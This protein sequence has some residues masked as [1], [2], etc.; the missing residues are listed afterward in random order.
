MEAFFEQIYSILTVPPGSLAYHLV[1]AFSIA[2]AL[3]IAVSAW[4]KSEGAH[5]RRWMLGL[6]LLLFLQVVQFGMAALGWQ[7]IIPTLTVLP[8][9][10]RGVSLLS[11]L[12][13]AWVWSFPRSSRLGDTAAVLLGL[14]IAAFMV[15]SISW[16]GQQVPGLTFNQTWL[17][18]GVQLFGILLAGLAGAGLL[19]RR[20]V[21]WGYGFGMLGLLM[22]GH[23]LQAWLLPEG[24]FAGIHRIFQMAAYPLLLLL[25]RPP[26]SVHNESEFIKLESQTLNRNQTLELALIRDYTH[27]ENEPDSGQFCKKITRSISKIMLA[28]FCLL[29]TP[30][31]NNNQMLVSCGYNLIQESYVDSFTLDGNLS[32]MITN[33]MKRGRPVRLTSANDSPEAYGLAHG[34]GIKRLGHLMHVP[35]CARASPA[36]MGILLITPFT[37]RAWTTDDQLGLVGST[38]IL[39]SILN[40]M[41]ASSEDTAAMA[42]MR[43]AA[44][45]SQHAATQARR[46]IENMQ[47]KADQLSR[48]LAEARSRAESL[49]SLISNQETLDQPADQV[50][51]LSGSDQSAKAA[52][53]ELIPIGDYRYL[54]SELKTTLHEMATLKNLLAASDLEILELKASQAT[55]RETEPAQEAPPNSEQAEVIASLAQ[56]LRQPMSSIVGYTD[57]LLGESIGI[58]GATQRK[59][60]ER[61]KASI[62]RM[63]GLV[64][65]LIQTTTMRSSEL[66]L[67]PEMVDLNT[68][69]DD[70]VANSIARLREKNILL[71]MDLPDRLPLVKADRDGL[72]QILIHLLQNAGAATPVEGE[73]LLRAQIEQKE[74]QPGYVLVQVSDSGGGIPAADMPRVFSRLY[75]ADNALIQGVGDTGVGLSIVK[76]LVEAHGGRVWVDSIMDVGSTF[77]VLLPLS[78]DDGIEHEAGAL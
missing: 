17:D 9:V 49:A 73:I 65:D 77:S 12:L 64:D 72:Q 60:L 43:E 25:P 47:T 71:R 23:L 27:L 28:D 44:A 66:E 30:P 69:I 18:F 11:L 68:I 61:V 5:S 67:S 13:I 41:Q 59:F 3:Q 70:A 63:G 75:R 39:A 54:E 10:D 62:E 34:L 56:E 58:L 53:A 24:N 1:L 29:I 36:L 21:G 35:V 33:S 7:E 16:F 4:Q 57:L 22:V 51:L 76:A 20:P 26:F 2:G 40:R 74:D 6:G 15:F 48:Q 52:T 46:E 45:N 31:D 32:P 14:F 78:N 19:L 55:D 42:R 38:E 8:P 50:V 37:N